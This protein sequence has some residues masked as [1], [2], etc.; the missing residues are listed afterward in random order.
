MF[1]TLA[2]AAA[3]GAVAVPALAATQVTVNVTGLDA[4][5]AHAVIYHAAQ[6]ACRTELADQSVLVRSYA[7]S[8]CVHDAVAGAETKLATL[9]GIAS[10]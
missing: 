9:R 5:A 4:K 7:W 8:D 10:R 2:L 1:R 6:A 3:L